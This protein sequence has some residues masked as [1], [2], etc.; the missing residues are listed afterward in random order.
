MQCANLEA[1]GVGY[2]C[3]TRCSGGGSFVVFD[4]LVCEN[5]SLSHQQSFN[6]LI[7][8]F[9]TDLASTQ[10][11]VPKRMWE[12]KRRLFTPLPYTPLYLLRL[13]VQW[14]IYFSLTEPTV[15]H[16]SPKLL[17]STSPTSTT[18]PFMGLTVD[19]TSYISV[20][21]ESSQ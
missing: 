5:P 3:G 18:V 20:I 11:P 15:S 6:L 17:P 12:D 21:R 8:T 19:A 9:S 2:R 7:L 10:R 4:M 16:H 1:G 13:S 14:H